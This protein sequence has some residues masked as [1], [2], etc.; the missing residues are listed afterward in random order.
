MSVGAARA[1]AGV[2]GNVMSM[3]IPSGGLLGAAGSAASVFAI[4]AVCGFCLRW[5]FAKCKQCWK[6]FDVRA[7]CGIDRL[8]LAWGIDKHPGFFIMITV[9]SAKDFRNTSLLGKA[10][11][12]VTVEAKYESCKTMVNKNAKWEETRRLAVPQGC[13]HVKLSLMDRKSGP[14]S[15][16]LIGS[17]QWSVDKHF[18]KQADKFL[19]VRKEHKLHAKDGSVAGQISLTFRKVDGTVDDSDVD[20]DP[21]LEGLDP[22][23][24]PALYGEVLN[25]MG[26][27][28]L[29]NLGGSRKVKVLASVLQGRLERRKSTRSLRGGGGAEVFAA[30]CQLLPRGSSDSEPDIEDLKR[31]AQE[32]GW[33]KDYVPKKWYWCLW[34][35]RKE[36]EKDPEDPDVMISVLSITSVH[37]DTAQSN[38]FSFKYKNSDGKSIEERYRTIRRD[39]EV[40]VDGL[41]LLRLECRLLKKSENDKLAY[42]RSRPV[43]EQMDAWKA[44]LRLRGYSDEEINEYYNHV[45]MQSMSKEERERAAARAAA[46]EGASATS[47]NSAASSGTGGPQGSLQSLPTKQPQPSVEQPVAAARP[48]PKASMVREVQPRPK[49]KAASRSARSPSPTRVPGV[50]GR[51]R[52]IGLPGKGGSPDGR[53][54]VPQRPGALQRPLLQQ[55]GKGARPPATNRPNRSGAFHRMSSS[56]ES[57]SSG[58]AAE[59]LPSAGAVSSSSGAPRSSS[60]HPLRAPQGRFYRNQRH[61]GNGLRMVF[62]SAIKGKLEDAGILAELFVAHTLQEI[63]G[64]EFSLDWWK[65][66]ARTACY[67][68]HGREGLDD[69]LGYDFEFLDTKGVFSKPREDGPR[70]VR[71]EV[72]GTLRSE[73]TIKFEMSRN[74]LAVAQNPDADYAVVL[75]KN[76]AGDCPGIQTVLTDFFSNIQEKRVDYKPSQYS[77]TLADPEL[78]QSVP[79]E[80]VEK[81]PSDT[82]SKIML[83][84]D[85]KKLRDRAKR[86]KRK[87]VSETPVTETEMREHQRRRMR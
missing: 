53:P 87:E 50:D 19:N 52:P 7:F 39:R 6:G 59:D 2:G 26:D 66:S 12:Y 24:H 16:S 42:W 83:V 49:A 61:S 13:S 71:L 79:K 35:S 60:Y 8:F 75:V 41:E 78:Y 62:D 65:T 1:V 55:G 18:F 43:G 51:P 33:A 20:E 57:L 29:R 32:K 86:M 54:R 37:R 58:S 28:V 72:K 81:R 67:P 82:E 77:I 17:V 5:C 40:W 31:K 25:V 30:V 45:L 36:F 44:E 85:E 23:L 27:E 63:Y 3:M 9:H 4:F 38:Y 15:D 76:A 22:D 74:E 80:I 21:L 14:R 69:R 10:N 48:E 47:V 56:P 84:S 68:E 46:K 34:E 64:D 73:G 11:L 70:W